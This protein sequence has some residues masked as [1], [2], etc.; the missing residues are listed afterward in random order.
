LGVH[1]QQA[2]QCNSLTLGVHPK[3]FNT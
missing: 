3:T 1:P 2:D